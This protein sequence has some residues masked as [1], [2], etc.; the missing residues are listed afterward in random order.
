MNTP[1]AKWLTEAVS[2]WS[3]RISESDLGVDWTEAYERCW[4]CGC[5]RKLQ[6][7]HIVPRSLG[8]K[9]STQNILALCSQCHDEMPNV[10]DPAAVW[11]WI[12]CDHGSLYDTY[13]TLRAISQHDLSRVDLK[14]LK[15]H[16]AKNSVGLHWSQGYGGSRISPGT[17][18]WLIKQ[19]Q[20]R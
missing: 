11:D 14:A 18:D 1:K 10:I 15:A 2:F 13:W 3:E 19:S 17:W 6:K 5:K 12:K 8:G 4:R 9:D 7:C 20:K 16:L